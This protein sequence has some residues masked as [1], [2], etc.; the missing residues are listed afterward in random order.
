MSN[1]RRILVVLTMATALCAD[2]VSLAA[3]ASGPR[4]AEFAQI[5]QRIVARL[6]QSF[7][8]NAPVSLPR[9]VRPSQPAARPVSA[10]IVVL[11]AAPAHQPVS[12][13]QFRLPP[14]IA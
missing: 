12:P 9:P 14:P 8:D 6:G 2:Q 11:D 3:P 7:R 4:A 1:P 5:A 13:F 10:F